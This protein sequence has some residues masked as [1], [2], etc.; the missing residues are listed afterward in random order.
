MRSPGNFRNFFEASKKLEIYEYCSS[1]FNFPKSYEC[2][3]VLSGLEFG[4][5]GR[6][7]R[8]ESFQLVSMGELFSHCV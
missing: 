7:V 1:V 4:F 2:F 8:C 3:E 6:V 5:Q